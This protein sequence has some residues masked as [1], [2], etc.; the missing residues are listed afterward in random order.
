MALRYPGIAME[1]E[2][3]A[4]AG[5]NSRAVPPDQVKIEHCGVYVPFLQEKNHAISLR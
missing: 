2:E 5:K 3:H 4:E 1:K